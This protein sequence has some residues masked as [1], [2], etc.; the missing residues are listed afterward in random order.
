M[1]G[2]ITEMVSYVVVE[3]MNQGFKSLMLERI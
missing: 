1:V 3:Y 2:L